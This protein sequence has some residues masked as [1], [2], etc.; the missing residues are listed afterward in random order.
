MH[1]KVSKLNL[2]WKHWCQHPFWIDWRYVAFEPFWGLDGIFLFAVGK[3]WKNNH[4]F[5]YEKW[6]HQWGLKCTIYINVWHDVQTYYVPYLFIFAG[7]GIVD[8]G[9]LS[10]SLQLFYTSCLWFYLYCT[11]WRRCQYLLTKN[12]STIMH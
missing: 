9:V 5:L 1:F 11:F 8:Y 6:I 2:I 7:W 10:S 3:G 4:E 12:W